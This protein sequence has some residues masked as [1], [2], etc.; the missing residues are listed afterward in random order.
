MHSAAPPSDECIAS[1]ANALVKLSWP[2]PSS[3][4]DHR[5]RSVINIREEEEARY[6]GGRHRLMQ[7]PP[8]WQPVPVS[9]PLAPRMPCAPRRLALALLVV[10]VRHV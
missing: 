10:A 6:R 5:A 2:T 7:L 3:R 1:A 9:V 8:R 4:L